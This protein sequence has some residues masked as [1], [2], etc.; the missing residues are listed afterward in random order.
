MPLDPKKIEQLVLDYSSLTRILIGLGF[1]AAKGI[2]ALIQ[3]Q[4]LT[5]EEREAILSRVMNNSTIR[6]ALA[7]ADAG[8]TPPPPSP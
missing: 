1:D 6:E 2:R 8:Q 3:S 7:R 5:P 4:A